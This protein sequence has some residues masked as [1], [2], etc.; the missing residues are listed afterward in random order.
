[1]PVITPYHLFGLNRSIKNHTVKCFAHIVADMFRIRH[2]SVRIDPTAGC[3]I[4]CQM[5][6][7]S[8]P[9]NR[10]HAIE[11]V[12][13]KDYELIA[14]RLYP[15]AFQVVLG[16]GSEPTLHPELPYFVEVAKKKYRV[17]HVGICTNGQLLDATLVDRLIQSGID[18]FI[19]SIHGVDK[20][21]YER[22]MPPG[23]FE[24]LHENLRYLSAKIAE[25]NGT[26]KFRINFTINPANFRGMASFFEIFGGYHL[27]MLQIRK[28]YKLGK[29][30]FRDYD[31]RPYWKELAKLHEKIELECKKRN[32]AFLCHSFNQP[33]SE[34]LPPSVIL[35]PLAYRHATPFMVWKDDFKWR[36]ES[37]EAYCKRTH[38]Y[39]EVIRM[40]FTPS[41]ILIPTIYQANRSL[42]WDIK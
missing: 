8:A 39:R 5:C 24:I 29:T 16:A 18:E 21:M 17:P 10:N 11:L 32:I 19:I 38:W 14:S 15:K 13:V 27:S 36:E 31:L 3:N 2:Y 33:P 9:E 7:F 4:R 22:F 41:R 25:S 34:E 23:K 42:Q 40:A 12:S 37:Y 30:D 28:I 1:M 6:H 20:E 26:K 35:L